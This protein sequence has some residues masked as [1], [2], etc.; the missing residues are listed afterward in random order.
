MTLR[1]FACPMLA[2][3]IAI[4][5]SQTPADVSKWRRTRL[6]LQFTRVRRHDES[7]ILPLTCSQMQPLTGRNGRAHGGHNGSRDRLQVTGNGG[8]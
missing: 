5:P 1:R 8:L 3:L 7:Q 4:A 2:I 6:R